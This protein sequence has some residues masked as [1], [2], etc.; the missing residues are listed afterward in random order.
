M[1]GASADAANHAVDVTLRATS[2]AGVAEGPWVADA[3]AG[4][5]YF[6]VTAASGGTQ[7]V[8]GNLDQPNG[9]SRNV[10]SLGPWTYTFA[11]TT[12]APDGTVE[13]DPQLGVA[14][15]R[16]GRPV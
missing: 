4:T 3:A 11:Q 12:G 9:C 1:K 14:G 7:T 5:L 6:R 2:P 10:P 16:A 15:Q 8:A 13:I